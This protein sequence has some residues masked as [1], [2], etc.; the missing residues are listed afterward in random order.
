MLYFDTS[1]LV[2]LLFEESTS[3][4][5][6]DF[7]ARQK[8]ELAV[9]HWT[10]LEFSSVLAREVRMDHLDRDAARDANIRFDALIAG[11]FV[12]LLP[13]AEDFE[14]AGQFLQR[15]ETR[16]RIGDAFHLAISK[17]HRA[18]AIHSL[19]KRLLEAGRVL[20]LPMTTGPRIPGYG[21]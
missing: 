21:R 16:L 3:A 18:T 13:T 2:P 9:S 5:I 8:G 1:F 4:L 14:L 6:Q 12:T 11:S 17:N 19:D 10:R 7:M 20:G 15:D